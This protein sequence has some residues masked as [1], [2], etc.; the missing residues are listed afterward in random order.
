MGPLLLNKEDTIMKNVVAVIVGVVAIAVTSA[1]TAGPDW[2]VIEQ[3]RKAKLLRLQNAMKPPEPAPG[4]STAPPRAP[5]QQ[6]QAEA[7]RRKCMEMMA[8]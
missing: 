4:A 1:A 3:A 5:D 8:K 2:Q 6:D 7:M